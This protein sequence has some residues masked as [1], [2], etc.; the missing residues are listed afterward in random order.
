M[1]GLAITAFTLAYGSCQLFW[2]PIGDRFGKH[3]VV[4][5]ACLLPAATTGAA[6]FAGS[7]ATL[8][9]LRLLSGVTAAAVIP[10]SM[11]FIGDHVAYEQRQ[12]TLARF[13]SGQILG[14]I[15]GQVIGGTVG[16]LLGWRAVFLVL[17]TLFLL[18]GLLAMA[19]LGLLRR[20]WTR[21]VLLT[22]LVEGLLLFGAFAYVGT[23]LRLAHGPD[24]TLIG[25]LL[26]SFGLGAW[27]TRSTCAASCAGWASAAWPVPAAPAL[28]SA[29]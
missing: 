20:P 10:L 6:A 13:M 25:A 2:G 19:C 28:P 7:L 5:L 14:L 3:R 16:D 11:A 24:Y 17:A 9:G 22:V 27:P 12:A 21:T 26:A 8:A 1:V 15:G 23:A 29:S 4:A 18:P